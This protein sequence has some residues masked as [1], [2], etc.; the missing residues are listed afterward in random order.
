M[1]EASSNVNAF[2]CPFQ[3]CRLLSIVHDTAE[4][5]ANGFG[6]RLCSS[7][8]RMRRL[9][10]LNWIISLNWAEDFVS[11][12]KQTQP[13]ECKS[14]VKAR[15]DVLWSRRLPWNVLSSLKCQNKFKVM[16]SSRLLLAKF[17]NYRWLQLRFLRNHEVL[18]WAWLWSWWN[19]K[20]L[21]GKLWNV[22]ALKITLATQYFI[23][24]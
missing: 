10:P 18:D 17:P 13:F 15:F 16:K 4:K 19:F 6:C 7:S 3:P 11:E 21:S 22:K 5:E 23:S 9:F 24:T 14:I 8:V 20:R 2:S 12:R 1:A